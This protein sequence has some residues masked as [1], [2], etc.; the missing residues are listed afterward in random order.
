M[1]GLLPQNE[2]TPPLFYCVAWVWARV[3]G[4]GEFAL[5]SLPALAGVATV[6]VMYAPP[7][8]SSAGAPASSRRR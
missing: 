7:P 4:F 2:T 6:P 3:F 8:S 1:L 5:R